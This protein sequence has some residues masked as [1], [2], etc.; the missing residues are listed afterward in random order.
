LT[1]ASNQTVGLQIAVTG[2][3]GSGKSTVCAGFAAL[4][5]AF[6]D[7]DSIAH[8]LT[9]PR[10]I[11][12][13]PIRNAFGDHFIDASGAMDRAAMRN[14]VFNDPTAKQ[15]LEAILHPLIRQ[16]TARLAVASLQNSPYVL[17]A[18]PLLFESMKASGSS[19]YQRILVVDCSVE[20]QRTRVANRNLTGA[21]A[22]AENARLV[23]AQIDVIIAAQA[24]REQRLS[25][26]TEVITNRDFQADLPQ[27]IAS[28]H[29]FYCVLARQH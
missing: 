19:R 4:G 26:A 18:I 10:G 15:R 21:H 27:Q 11:A 22:G 2:G 1:A 17:V 13:D 6:V 8:A 24:S 3:I 28:L 9:Q 29:Q 12:I 20:E 5:A 14:H 16:E 25:I 23:P 7:T